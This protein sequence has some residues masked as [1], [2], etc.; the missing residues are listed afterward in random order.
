LESTKCSEI[1]WKGYGNEKFDFS[2]PNVCMIYN[3]GELTLIEYG[4][5]EILGNCR[6]EHMKKNLIS[7]RLAN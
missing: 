6:T 1:K 2:N 4:N 3:A 7:A 5:D